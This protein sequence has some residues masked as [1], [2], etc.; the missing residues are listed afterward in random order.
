MLFA[1]REGY[2]LALACSTPWLN[3]ST[4]FV[5]T[6]DGWQDL[7]QHKLMTWS[8]ER[9]DNG[10]VALTG[11]VD[12]SACKGDFIIGIGFGLNYAEAAQRV[13]ASLSDGFATARDTYIRQWTDWQSRLLR[14]LTDG[15][16]VAD[17]AAQPPPT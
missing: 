17:G 13:M 4:G 5:G 10:N 11:E 7:N 12:L 16:L 2:A 8:Y 15:N 14:G 9:A 3:R 1:E 6:S